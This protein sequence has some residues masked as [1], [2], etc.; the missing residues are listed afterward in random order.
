MFRRLFAAP[1]IALA[2]GLAAAPGPAGAVVPASFG[3]EQRD[4]LAKAE[5]ALSGVRSL[6]ARFQQMTSRG[7]FAEGKV[8]IERPGHMRLEY[9]PPT[10][11]L[12]VADGSYL[13]YADLDLRQ[14]SHIGLDETPAG[15]LL[16][17]AVSFADPD[18]TVRDVRRVS[19]LV[20]IDV[21][22]TDEPTAGELTLVFAEDGF[23]LRQ[24]RVLDAEGVETTVALSQVRTG[25]DL[26]DALFKHIPTPAALPPRN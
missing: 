5:A 21:V 8:M 1:L 9:D 10:D 25:V 19:G 11:I 20:E 26:D 17:D 6:T 4:A 23:A 16:R 14:V 2:L 24:W 3:A 12:I 15:I 18:V 22:M 13:I 7:G